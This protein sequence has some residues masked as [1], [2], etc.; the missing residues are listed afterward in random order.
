MP[1]FVI[2]SLRLCSCRFVVL[3]RIFLLIILNCYFIMS[4]RHS[5]SSS[6]VAKLLSAEPLSL[7]EDQEEKEE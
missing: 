5:L 7:E 1:S 2:V 6:D 4:L 3:G